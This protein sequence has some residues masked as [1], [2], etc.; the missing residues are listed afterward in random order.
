MNLKIKIDAAGIAAQFKEFAGEVE[1]EIKKSA[2][3]LATITHAKAKELAASELKKSASTFMNALS[4][5][6]V[7]PNVWVITVDEGGMWIEE[8]IDAGFDMKPGLLKDSK[9][10]ASG[11]KYRVVPFEHS[12]APSQMT[13]NARQIVNTLREGL[14]KANVPFKKIETDNSGSPRTGKL[15]QLNIP[16]DI[17]GK[18]NTPS[19][20]RVSIYQKVTGSGK[21]RRD[22]FTFRTVVSGPKGEGKWIHPGFQKKLF[23]DRSYDWALQRWEQEILPS[24]LEKWK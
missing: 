6:E 1:R 4:F 19:L 17:P 21:V 20:K 3:E 18:G 11:N 2:K 24:I 5:E 7:A 9:T 14:K 8:G 12:K 10:S 15:H 13:E 16:S 22:I 23:L